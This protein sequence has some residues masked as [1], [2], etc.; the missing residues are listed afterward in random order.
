MRKN[1]LRLMKAAVPFFLVGIVFLSLLLCSFG[2]RESEA[3]SARIVRIWNIDTFEGGRGSRTSFLKRVALKTE[4]TRR[5]VYYLVSSYTAEGAREA[6]G[7]GDFPDLISFGIGLSDFAELSLTLSY[8]FAGGETEDGC[9]AYPWCRG[10]YALF[11]LEED[12]DGEGVTAISCGGEN[13]PQVAA[14]LSGISGEEVDSVAAYTGFLSGKYRYLL[15]TQR[16]LCRLSARNMT[17]YTSPLSEYCDLYQYI[18]VLSA[19]KRS[20]CDA[21]LTMLFSEEVQG[22]LSQIGMYP[23]TGASDFVTEVKF[24]ASVFSSQTALEGLKEAARTGERKSIENYLK[25]I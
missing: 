12:F 22:E 25:N 24:T 5:G 4:K 1:F 13:L 14:A 8:S 7:E 20:D 10:G 17:V 9:L 3:E 6:L 19:E 23:M 21:F 15:G 16:D 18:S 2:K 11:S